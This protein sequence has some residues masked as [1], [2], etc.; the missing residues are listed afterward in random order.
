MKQPTILCV[1]DEGGPLLMRQL[2]LQD[3]GFRV[4][5]ATNI[6]Q[7][8]EVFNSDHVELVVSDHLLEHG[9]GA[10][11]ARRLKQL[12]P[13]VP[14]IL[15]SGLVDRPEEAEA[16]DAFVNKIEGRDALIAAIKE[17]LDHHSH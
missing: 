8:I 15:L 2:V 4:L 6:E 13:A 3:A 14:F 1:D 17:M 16:V 7:A 10:E 12:N 11:L 9:T 5:T